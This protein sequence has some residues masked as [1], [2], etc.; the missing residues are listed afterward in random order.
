VTDVLQT[1]LIF[2][3]F[4]DQ[5]AAKC[6]QHTAT[7]AAIAGGIR[8]AHGPDK[9]SLPWIKLATFGTQRSPKNCLRTNANMLTANGN[10]CEY[11]GEVMSFDA[12]ANRLFAHD[13]GGVFYTSPSHRPTAPRWRFLAP[14]SRPLPP[15]ERRRMV[16]RVNGVLGGILAPE[17]FTLSQAFLAG[18]VDANAANHRV[19]LIPGRAIDLCDELDTMAI[20]PKATVRTG[21][22][23]GV[24]GDDD[25]VQEDADLVRTIVKADAGLH[26]ALVALAARLIGR[27]GSR[28]SV[29]ST[30]RAMLETV[31]AAERDARWH[32]RRAEIPAIVDSAARKFAD[33]SGDA[34]R[35]CARVL[36]RLTQ[37]HCD[38][39][40]MWA[41]ALAEV[42]RHGVTGDAARTLVDRVADWCW[43][44]RFSGAVS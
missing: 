29:E 35:A 1:P 26:P 15:A 41:A 12:G 19:E 27:G 38:L 32:E 17:S 37:T 3:T 16:A 10:E 5:K 33:Q 43:G 30:L 14:F 36:M 25:E 22:G 20:G 13:I 2:T 6:T 44:K 21:Q 11:D 18:Y 23:G 39:G 7:P 8:K 28:A 42:A 4:P 34:F 24:A 31:P 40:T 9:F